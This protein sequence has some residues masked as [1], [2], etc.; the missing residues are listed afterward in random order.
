MKKSGQRARTLNLVITPLLWAW[1]AF[2]VGIWQ[3]AVAGQIIAITPYITFLLLLV[4]ALFLGI[5]A[6][7][8]YRVTSHHLLRPALRILIL[9]AISTPFVGA[10]LSY[11]EL[12]VLAEFPDLLACRVFWILTSCGFVVS[13]FVCRLLLTI[14][15]E[16]SMAEQST[17]FQRKAA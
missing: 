14:M 1:L 13:Q 10:W 8:L 16:E 11:C 5:T 7:T 2:S 9:A 6:S 12:Q 4:M 3:F 17:L 15:S